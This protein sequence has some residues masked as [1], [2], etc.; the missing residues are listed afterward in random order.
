MR[1]TAE[2]AITAP[3]VELFE[4]LSDLENHWRLTGKGIEVFKLTGEPGHRTGG[5]VR[6][7]GPLGISRT[8]QTEVLAAHPH[9]E[10]HGRARIG[11]STEAMIRWRLVPQDNE[12]TVVTLDADAHPGPLDRAL[13]IAG[14]QR[15]MTRLFSR[16]L[17]RL[18]ERF[19]LGAPKSQTAPAP[20][21]RAR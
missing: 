4:F 2:R 21:G 1:I 7:R 12:R 3:A 11:R 6:I 5:R 10:M 17:D 15:W 18:A 20:V 8:V 14:G 13:L 19:E 9:T 16:T